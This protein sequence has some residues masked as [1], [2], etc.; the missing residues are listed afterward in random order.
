M[1]T[2]VSDEVRLQQ[3]RSI[4]TLTTFTYEGT[5]LKSLLLLHYS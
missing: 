5:S 2:E 1:R 4:G 3:Q